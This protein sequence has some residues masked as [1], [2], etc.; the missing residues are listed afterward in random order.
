[1]LSVSSNKWSALDR[2]SSDEKSSSG[3]SDSIG[4]S[5]RVLRNCLPRWICVYMGTTGQSGKIIDL[6][7]EKN[8][9]RVF[10]IVLIMFKK[11]YNLFMLYRMATYIMWCTQIVHKPLLLEEAWVKEAATVP[12][13]DFRM[14]PS[15][16]KKKS[17]VNE[18]S[19]LLEGTSLSVVMVDR[20]WLRKMLPVGSL[21]LNSI[22][23]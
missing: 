13:C 17:L 1:M 3:T 12:L 22:S 6:W 8:L 14:W 18:T 16:V 9:E 4:F 19:L 21:W 20:W 5:W 11:Y 7:H 2:T 23:L 10:K 15:L